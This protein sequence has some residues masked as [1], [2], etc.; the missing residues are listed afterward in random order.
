MAKG[1]LGKKIGMTQVFSAQGELIPVTVIEVTNNVGG[2][3]T[4]TKGL[5]NNVTATY[6]S[7]REVTDELNTNKELIKVTDTLGLTTEYKYDKDNNNIVQIDKTS[8]E[9]TSPQLGDFLKDAAIMA[10]VMSLL[11]LFVNRE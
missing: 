9:E 1:I 6:E 5:D 11:D 8:K 2:K 3:I 4:I 7:G 10:A